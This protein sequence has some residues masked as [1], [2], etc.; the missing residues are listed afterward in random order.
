MH[1]FPSIVSRSKI[2]V[3]SGFVIVS[4]GVDSRSG[5]TSVVTSGCRNA[6][7]VSAGSVVPI[8]HTGV[9]TI[10][11]WLGCLIFVAGVGAT[12]VMCMM[13]CF[14]SYH[15]SFRVLDGGGMGR[16]VTSAAFEKADAVA[17]RVVVGGGW[18]ISL[19]FPVI[20]TEPDLDKG[21]D[22]EDERSNDCDSH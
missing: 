5:G 14:W 7:I 9:M 15:T 13:G 19:L 11:C 8:E 12:V 2:V 1:S 18:S 4:V 3:R 21:A 20:A 6:S 17:F 16:F 10:I 22:E